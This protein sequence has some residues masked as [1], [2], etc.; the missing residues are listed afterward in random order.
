[1]AA[2]VAA[3]LR[4]FAGLAV[5]LEPLLLQVLAQPAEAWPCVLQ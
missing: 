3:P 1:V 2:G 5:A 4:R